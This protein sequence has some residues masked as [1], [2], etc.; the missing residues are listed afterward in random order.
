ML[1]KG[2]HPHSVPKNYKYLPTVK[3]VSLIK[4]Q[5]IDVA[6]IEPIQSFLKLLYRLLHNTSI[7]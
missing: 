4:A 7:M 5:D 2:I 6:S 3:H 1:L